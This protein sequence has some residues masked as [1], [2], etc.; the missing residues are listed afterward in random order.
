MINVAGD[1]NMEYKTIFRPSSKRVILTIVLGPILALVGYFLIAYSL[2][3][4]KI[5][6]Y[7]SLPL[8]GPL[9]LSDMF[10]MSKGLM[11]ILVWNLLVLIYYYIIFSIISF[12]V[13]KRKIKKLS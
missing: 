4:G 3:N 7:L 9:L 11:Y 8:L 2:N 6:E 13:F 1:S 5:Y 12:L 10:G